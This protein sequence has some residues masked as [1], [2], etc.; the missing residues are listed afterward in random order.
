MKLYAFQPEGHGPK[1]FFVMSESEEEARKAVSDYCS[2]IIFEG[3]TQSWE[4]C[5]T[6]DCNPFYEHDV[7][8]LGPNEV[9]E[10]DND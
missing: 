4:Y 8:E 2:K 1:S 5:S 10:N 3:K 9:V 7:I 6:E